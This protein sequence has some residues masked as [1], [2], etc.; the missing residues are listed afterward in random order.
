MLDFMSQIREGVTDPGGGRTVKSIGERKSG[1]GKIQGK[2]YYKKTLKEHQSVKITIYDKRKKMML[3]SSP[4]EISTTLTA[5]ARCLQDSEKD[6][7]QGSAEGPPKCEGAVAVK[8]E[9]AAALP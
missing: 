6:L 3:L 8:N 4:N 9:T 5:E 2:T 1:V 7:S